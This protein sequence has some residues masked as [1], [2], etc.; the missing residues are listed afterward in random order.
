MHPTL[1]IG[2][3][4]DYNPDL[5]YHSATN[6]ALSQSCQLFR[7]D[8]ACLIFMN[9]GFSQSD[10]LLNVSASS[11]L[12]GDQALLIKDAVGASHRAEIDP[13]VNCHLAHGRQLVTWLE[14]PVRYQ[15][16]NLAYDLL[17]YGIVCTEIQANTPG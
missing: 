10:W 9:T 11:T 16:F 13:Q 3:I 4:G 5:R 7:G 8:I 12:G 1:K 14:H 17:E 2:I 15:S 6:E